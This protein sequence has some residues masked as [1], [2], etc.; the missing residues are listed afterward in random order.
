MSEPQAGT[1]TPEPVVSESAGTAATPVADGSETA[2]AAKPVDAALAMG[3]KEKAEKYNELE[4]SGRLAALET[5]APSPTT[6]P[7]GGAGQ[8]IPGVN[9]SE[10][11]QAIYAIRGGFATDSDRSL[12]AYAVSV[13]QANQVQQLAH[14]TRLAAI[15]EAERSGTEQMFRTGEYKTLEAA[16]KA[17]KGSL[18]PAEYANLYG[19]KKPVV[20]NETRPA[21]VDTS[22]AS[23]GP[24]RTATIKDTNDFLTEI[25]AAKARGDTARVAELNRIARGG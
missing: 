13:A 18:S 3:W 11:Q 17:W 5:P 25:R 24:T 20:N 8:S 15:P 2:G 7:E 4:R 14:E 16:R 1:P 19:E 22:T 10:L 23:I 6:A 21:P 9:D 12:V